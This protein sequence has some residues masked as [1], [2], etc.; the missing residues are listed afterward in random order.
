MFRLF[1]VSFSMLLIFSC[2]AWRH[3][4][5]ETPQQSL[6]D[7]QNTR[8]GLCKDFTLES[9]PRCDRVTFASLADIGC[10]A[11]DLAV[12]EY[13]AGKINRDAS[14]CWADGVDLGSSSECSLDG[15]LARTVTAIVHHDQDTPKRMIAYLDTVD[16]ICGGGANTGV[17]SIKIIK[18]MIYKAAGLQALVG[19]ADALPNPLENFR[20]NL[21]ALWIYGNALMSGSITEAGQ[22]AFDALVK[23]A[24][25]SPAYAALAHRWKDGDY[26]EMISL[27][28]DGRE[29]ASYWGSCPWAAY[30]GWAVAISEKK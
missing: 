13:P 17:T 7:A 2:G 22:L 24:P 21:L 30:V 29:C 9:T 14:P 5:D 27:V 20:G 12:Y 8:D 26:G 23:E 1:A 6:Q 18:P 11:Q 28:Q 25:A 4:D 15:Y 16:W 10:K 3:Q 19:E